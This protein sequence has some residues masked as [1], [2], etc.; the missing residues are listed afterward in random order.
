MV[1]VLGLGGLFVL[2]WR[3]A[4]YWWVGRQA[5]EAQQVRFEDKE[6]KHG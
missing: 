4:V 5:R 1:I 3:A 6:I 2:G